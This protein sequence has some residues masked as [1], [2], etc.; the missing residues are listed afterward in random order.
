MNSR[1]AQVTAISSAS[2]RSAW[3]IQ[4]INAER[5][6]EIRS[7]CHRARMGT[8][9]R[10]MQK[11]QVEDVLR[12]AAARVRS[13]K[14]TAKRRPASMRRIALLA[15]AKMHGYARSR[16]SKPPRIHHAE[17]PHRPPQGESPATS[18]PARV[19]V[20][21]G[22][23]LCDRQSAPNHDTRAIDQQWAELIRVIK[24]KKS[25]VQISSHRAGHTSTIGT[26][27]LCVNIR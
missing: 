17:N 19:P 13:K 25:R 18:Q 10:A 4:S 14:A 3:L 16:L 8:L 12:D 9:V 5:R 22:G 27:Q 1:N 20:A 23:E 6:D 7:T 2:S 11:I 15:R 21:V 24:M 26:R